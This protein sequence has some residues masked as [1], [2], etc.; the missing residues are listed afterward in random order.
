MTTIEKISNSEPTSVLERIRKI[1]V[2]GA[3]ITALGFSLLVAGCTDSPKAINEQNTPAE[4]VSPTTLPPKEQKQLDEVYK[5]I[6]LAE[7]NKIYEAQLLLSQTF[8]ESPRQFDKDTAI[9]FVNGNDL[10]DEVI[11]KK[12]MALANEGKYKEARDLAMYILDEGT[13]NRE[14][15]NEAINAIEAQNTSQ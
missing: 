3:A 5:A 10:V 15:A 6:R 2:V 13:T 11:L 9:N 4:Q 7:N 14:T 1:K 8:E 12:A